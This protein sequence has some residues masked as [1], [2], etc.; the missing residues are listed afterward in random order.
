MSFI[1]KFETIIASSAVLLLVFFMTTSILLPNLNQAN[2]ILAQ[3]KTLRTKLDLLTSKNNVLSS[4]D[5]QFYKDSFLKLNQVLPESKDY[6][7]LIETFDTLE[8][9]SGVSVEKTDFQLGAIS[10]N[11]STLIKTSGISAY[12]V[13]INIGIAGDLETVKKFLES[14]ANFTG[15]LL[16][17]DDMSLNVKPSGFLD[18][19][20]NGRAFFYPLPTTLGP[21]DTALSRLDKNQ[22]EILDK[23]S[24]SSLAVTGSEQAFDKG[25]IGKKI[26]FE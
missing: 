8:K 14:V 13:P 18:V 11:S 23:I 19:S 16:V 1:R 20:F 10:T 7:S 25:S 22:Q 4:L 9:Q 24:Q 5:Y 3:E 21:I 2:K 12:V 15:R 17:F 26:L 6:V